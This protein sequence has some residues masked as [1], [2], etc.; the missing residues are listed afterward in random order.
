MHPA[1]KALLRLAIGMG[2]TVL[3][4]YGLPLQLPFV[5][6]VL[7][8]VLL[9]KPGPPMPLVKGLVVAFVVALL[10]AVGMLMVPV[11]QHYAAAGVLLTAVV[12]FGLFFAGARTANPLSTILVI[13]FAI[14]PVAGVAS[15][16]FAIELGQSLA[17]GF[18]VGALVGGIS[19]ALFPDP[20]RATVPAAPAGATAQAAGWTALRATLVVMPVFVLALT[21]PAFYIAAIMK[22]TMLGQ[23]AGATSARAAGKELVGSTLMGA[24]MAAAV[25]AGL[26]LRPNLWM[27]MLWI[28]AATFW[29][30]SRL[31]RIR[32]TSVAP[33]FWVNAL[34]TMFILLGPAIEDA[35]VGKDV[36][37]ASLFRVTL[38]VVVSLYAWATV[39]VLEL[40]SSWPARSRPPV[41]AYTQPGSGHRP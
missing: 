16:P 33:S 1:D 25:W 11:L 14:I 38:F 9:A 37:N 40:I 6:C 10:L 13:S 20:P 15:Q 39:W 17:V 31:F 30:G 12:L 24:L 27:L 22:T 4:A 35:A 32:R 8:V 3:I 26:T 2:L 41:P 29:A 19:H 34:M 7:A 28:V 36:F 5:S 18:G 21:N 23:Q